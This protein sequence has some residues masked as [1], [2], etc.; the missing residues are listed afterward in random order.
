[1]VSVQKLA[2]ATIARVKGAKHAQP[3]SNIF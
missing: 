1:V 3:P 2:L